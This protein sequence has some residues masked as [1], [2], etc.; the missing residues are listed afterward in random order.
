MYA[1]C[2]N[3]LSQGTTCKRKIKEVCKWFLPLR[4][5]QIPLPN[6]YTSI[7]QES[8]IRMQGQAAFC[9]FEN[10]IWSRATRTGFTEKKR[11]R[12]LTKQQVPK[13]RSTL[14]SELLSKY[15][16]FTKNLAQNTGKIYTIHHDHSALQKESS[17]LKHADHF[18]QKSLRRS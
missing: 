2:R 10:N 16:D 12:R 14:I 13:P 4:R 17:I 6:S 5:Y 7:S 8:S 1:I 15:V 11:G 3:Q 18:I 9:W